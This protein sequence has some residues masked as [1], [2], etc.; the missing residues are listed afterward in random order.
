MTITTN[1][2]N[3]IAAIVRSD[4]KNISPY[5][6][7]YLVAMENMDDINKDYYEDSGVSVVL[8]FLANAQQWRGPVARDIKK[9]LN[10]L[11]KGAK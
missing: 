6:D 8:Y 1:R 4:W 9:H 10:N 7:A 5:A 11:V 2:L 3:E